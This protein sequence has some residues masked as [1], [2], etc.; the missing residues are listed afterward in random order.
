MFLNTVVDRLFTLYTP[1]KD[2]FNGDTTAMTFDLFGGFLIAITF[3]TIGIICLSLAGSDKAEVAYNERKS[4]TKLFGAF[5][6]FCG[7]SRFINEISLWY[8]YAFIHAIVKDITGLTALV[9]LFYLPVVIKKIKEARSIND[10]DDSVK[11]ANE[12]L[13][14]VSEIGSKL[15]THEHN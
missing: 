5:L 9:A 15:N 4:L 6:L 14:I 8:N 1:I 12:K 7:V 11:K 2:T 13:K 10:L 3:S